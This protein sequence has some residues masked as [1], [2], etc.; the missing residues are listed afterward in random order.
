[1]KKINFLLVI[2]VFLSM[3]GSVFGETCNIPVEIQLDTSSWTSHNYLSMKVCSDGTIDDDSFGFARSGEFPDDNSYESIDRTRAESI[4]NNQGIDARDVRDIRT[5]SD[6]ILRSGIE[7]EHYVFERTNNMVRIDSLEIGQEDYG[8]G[9]SGTIDTQLQRIHPPIAGEPYSLSTEQTGIPEIIN[10]DGSGSYALGETSNQRY[11]KVNGEWI[12]ESEVRQNEVTGTNRD[13][14]SQNAIT[15]TQNGVNSPNTPE[16]TPQ[17]V[18]LNKFVKDGN[19]YCITTQSNC[20]EVNRENMYTESEALEIY[21]QENNF[22]FGTAL[23]DLAQSNSMTNVND[24]RRLPEQVQISCIQSNNCNRITS[25]LDTD[26]FFSLSV[27]VRNQCITN[28]CGEIT[29]VLQELSEGNDIPSGIGRDDFLQYQQA[30][31]QINP[32]IHSNLAQ[33]YNTLVERKNNGEELTENEEKELKDLKK[34]MSSMSTRQISAV[35]AN[36]GQFDSIFASREE[37]GGSIPFVGCLWTSTYDGERLGVEMENTIRS[38]VEAICQQNPTSCDSTEK[39]NEL[40]LGKL[41]EWANDFGCNDLIECDIDQ[42]Q[43]QCQDQ[44]C[45]T[46]AQALEAAKEKAYN[47]MAVETNFLYDIISVLG[48]PDPAAIEAAAFFGFEANYDNVPQFLREP[49]ESTICIAKI[50][51]YLDKDIENNGGITKYDYENGEVDVVADLRAQRTPVTPDGKTAISY[52]YFLKANNGD[53]RYTIGISY[54]QDGVK[55]KES[56]F[57]EVKNISAGGTASGFE[58]INLPINLSL[59][60][61]D[62]SSFVIGLLAVDGSG[63]PTNTLTY[64]IMLINNGDYYFKSVGGGNSNGNEV[65]KNQ[66][67]QPG[68]TLQD[69]L[70]LMN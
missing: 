30:G 37:C 11:V 21:F 1:M 14:P 41:N 13:T 2:L 28:N 45:R 17:P 69:L 27:N 3:I 67:N 39:Y 38:E 61:V 19:K 68:L 51:G 29:Y 43:S 66:T 52:S 22:E 63:S 59:G 24:F 9:L 18:N 56:V 70:S 7:R 4:L 8:E 46:K 31:F 20:N 23:G 62:E 35:I 44:T 34:I 36:G 55:R 58:N 40:Y 16:V 10:V 6:R 54:I 42:I 50:E 26:S 25:Q 47:N 33:K 53:L 60:T 48:N 57:D 64:P 49:M 15:P 12:L 65:A 5:L 32:N